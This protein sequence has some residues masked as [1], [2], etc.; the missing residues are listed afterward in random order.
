[1]RCSL[2]CLA[3][4]FGLAG[5]KFDPPPAQIVNLDVGDSCNA[6]KECASGLCE[7]TCV[8][9]RA[10][11]PCTGQLVCVDRACVPPQVEPTD[12][13]SVLGGPVQTDGSGRKHRGRVAVPAVTSHR[14]TAGEL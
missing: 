6:D 5:C 2:V 14:K 12:P 1:M 13:P 9:C 8:E 11:A 7:A 4:L 10:D 3:L